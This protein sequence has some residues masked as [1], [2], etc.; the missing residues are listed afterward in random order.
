V[1]AKRTPCEPSGISRRKNFRLPEGNTKLVLEHADC[2]HRDL[3]LPKMASRQF[4]NYFVRLRWFRFTWKEKGIEGTL[5]WLQ[6]P[7]P[8]KV[9]DLIHCIVRKRVLTHTLKALRHP[10][11]RSIQ[12]ACFG[13]QESPRSPTSETTVE[14]ALQNP[15]PQK[16][17]GEA[18]G[19]T[20]G[21]LASPWPVLD[22]R[23]TV[24]IDR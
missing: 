3:P 7:Q 9:S 11:S 14:S 20:I 5:G 24:L 1:L 15:T 19:V 22:Y 13:C 12:K 2:N 18:P 17:K 4:R 10:E 8:N 16:M 21:H 6:A 23:L